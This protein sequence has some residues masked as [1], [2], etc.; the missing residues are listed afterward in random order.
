MTMLNYKQ[1]SFK[2]SKKNFNLVDWYLLFCVEVFPAD[3][4][5]ASLT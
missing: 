1:V 4:A 2:H 5:N 3:K